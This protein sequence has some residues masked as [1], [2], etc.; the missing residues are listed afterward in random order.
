MTYSRPGSYSSTDVLK[1]LQALRMYVVD[2]W[3]G[4][5]TGW[6]QGF[7]QLAC[8]GIGVLAVSTLLV[9]GFLWDY[10][11]LFISS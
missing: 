3:S 2:L 6:Q 10:S 5:S 11:K 8:V 7:F 9:G 4:H 1:G